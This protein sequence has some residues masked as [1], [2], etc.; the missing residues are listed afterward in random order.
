V[1]ILDIIHVLEYIWLIAH[2]KYKE[3]SNEAKAYVYEKLYSG[4]IGM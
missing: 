2:T 4:K 1:L 3:G